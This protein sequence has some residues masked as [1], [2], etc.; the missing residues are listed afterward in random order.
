MFSSLDFEANEV[1]CLRKRIPKGSVTFYAIVLLDLWHREV[2]PVWVMIAK[3]MLLHLGG[4]SESQ[5]WVGILSLLW[6]YGGWFI[7]RCFKEPV[8]S[9]VETVYT[10]EYSIDGLDP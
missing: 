7:S 1:C 3:V 4:D 6:W 9:N 10:H 2:Q 8:D 5:R